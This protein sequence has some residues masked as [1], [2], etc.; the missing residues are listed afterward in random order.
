[1]P[2]I[3]FEASRPRVTLAGDSIEATAE[4]FEGKTH[5]SLAEP[6]TISAGQSLVVDVWD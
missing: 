1:M 3:G 2:L 6:V 5:L 4:V